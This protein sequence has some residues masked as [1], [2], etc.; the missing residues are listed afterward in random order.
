M[1]EC[2]TLIS[3]HVGPNAVAHAYTACRQPTQAEVRESQ[4]RAAERLGNLI[5]E[6]LGPNSFLPMFMLTPLGTHKSKWTKKVQAIMT[7]AAFNE[8]EPEV[9]ETLENFTSRKHDYVWT[10]WF[11]RSENE[12]CKTLLKIH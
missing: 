6:L 2:H 1:I 8:R 12:D 9:I 4:S 5:N 3:V 10:A 11:M 7:K